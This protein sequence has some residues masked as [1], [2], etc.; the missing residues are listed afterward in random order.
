MKKDYVCP[1][2]VLTFCILF[3]CWVIFLFFFFKNNF[4][5]AVRVSNGV[6]PDQDRHSVGPDLSPNW[7]RLLA[8]DKSH[9][10]VDRASLKT[11]F[12]ENQGPP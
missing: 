9:L 4:R 6:D 3:A 7:Q 12:P 8:D 11:A 10:K 1:S 5:N 2:F